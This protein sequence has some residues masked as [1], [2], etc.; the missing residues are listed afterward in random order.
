MSL[1]PLPTQYCVDHVADLGY[2]FYIHSPFTPLRK[3]SAPVAL[4]KSCR[5][6]SW[7]RA[8]GIWH[9]SEGPKGMSPGLQDSKGT[10]VT[11]KFLK[12]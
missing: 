12:V 1:N 9:W 8:Q 2:N 10:K 3:M 6:G 11:L 7:S 4:Q 5:F